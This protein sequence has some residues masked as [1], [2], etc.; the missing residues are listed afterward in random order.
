[1]NHLINNTTKLAHTLRA[2]RK[3]LK[4]SQIDAANRSGLY[5]K[6]V[7]LLENNPEKCSVD[8]FMKHISSLKL[9][10]VLV[11]SPLASDNDSS[12]EW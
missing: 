3:R 5:T 7:S 4:W 10:F 6:T 8:T 11:D 9:E 12:Q 2:A 1:M